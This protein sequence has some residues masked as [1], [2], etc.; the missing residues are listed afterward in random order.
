VGTLEF[1]EESGMGI[2]AVRP[3]NDTGEATCPD[4]GK[5]SQVGNWRVEVAF[6]QPKPWPPLNKRAPTACCISL[7]ACPHEMARMLLVGREEARKP[8]EIP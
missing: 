8:S 2:G 7:N 3:S 1:V 5:P 6:G 4:G